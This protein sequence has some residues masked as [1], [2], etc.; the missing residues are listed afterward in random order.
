MSNFQ[1]IVFIDENFFGDR[2]FSNATIEAGSGWYGIIVKSAGSPTIA[3]VTPSNTGAVALTTDN[4]SEIQKLALTHGDVLDLGAA[5]LQD[6]RIAFSLAGQTANTT[7]WLGVAGAHNS[8]LTSVTPR[9]GIKIVNTTIT[10]ETHDGNS[11]TTAS[12]GVT[13]SSTTQWLAISFAYGLSDVRFY[14]QNSSGQLTRICT[15]TTFNMSAVTGSLQPY[16]RVEKTAS[17]DVPILTLDKVFIQ[18]KM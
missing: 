14:L 17:T 8:T 3:S 11:L 4:T 7:A 1:N 5:N 18:G 12:S 9:C 13:Y 6:V 2:S 15:G 10:A 16:L